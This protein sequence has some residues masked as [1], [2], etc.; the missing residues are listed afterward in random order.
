MKS[1]RLA[2]AL[3]LSFAPTVLADPLFDFYQQLHANPELSHFETKTAA[4]LA[5][6]LRKAGFQVTTGIGKYKDG[7][8]AH[9]VVAVLENGAGPRLLIRADMD[10]LPIVEETNLPYA[11][12]VTSTNTAGQQ[13]GVMHAC[14]HDIHTTTLLGTAREMAAR[15]NEWQG[16]LVL[17]GQPSEETLDG[18]Q[19]ML[20]DGLYQR[21]GKPDMALAM[22]VS[23]G[24]ATGVI[25]VYAGATHAAVTSID[26]TIRGIGGHGAA[27][28]R[29]KDPVVMAAQ[30]I[31]QIQTIVSRNQ[32]PLDPAVV[33][34]GSI[35]GGTKRNIIPDEVKL[36]LTTR[37]HSEKAMDIIVA[38]IQQAAEGVA[39]SN[40]LPAERKP[41]VKIIETETGPANINDKQLAIKVKTAIIAALGASK[42]NDGFPIMGSEDFALYSLPGQQIP[43]VLFNVGVIPAE[44]LAQAKAG[45]IHVAGTHTSRFAPEAKPAIQAG[46][47]A[48]TAAAIDLLQK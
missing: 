23:A 48:M 9:G 13:V 3:C 35:H 43:T 2:A 15:R 27:P 22:H 42:V 33:T 34:V 21:F 41:I 28:H 38:G 25:G 10:A 19:A 40:G 47:Q 14:G 6:E 18:A 17:V 32:D 4:L 29:G 8:Q 20:R 44:L 26:V 46:V 16:T 11:S 45:K 30:F 24:L 12:K 36:E 31:N 37:A 1:S 39:V 5:T 7:S